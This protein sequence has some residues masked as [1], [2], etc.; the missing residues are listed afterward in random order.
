VDHEGEFNIFVGLSS[1]ITDEIL[2][3]H[4]RNLRFTQTYLSNKNR[5][6]TMHHWVVEDSM[7]GANETMDDDAYDLPYSV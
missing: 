6:E 3:S 1:H 5:L 2:K 7:V 4:P